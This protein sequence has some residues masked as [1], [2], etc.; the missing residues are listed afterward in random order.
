MED[1]I[2]RLG[3]KFFHAG[4]INA[5]EYHRNKQIF[6]QSDVISS[7]STILN[8]FVE[9][10]TLPT[11]QFGFTPSS[12]K[13]VK[14]EHM[15]D[16]DKETF[17]EHW[18]PLQ[19]PILRNMLIGGF[20]VYTTRKIRG[21][22]L[23]PMDITHHIGL[24]FDVHLFIDVHTFEEHYYVVPIQR[25]NQFHASFNMRHA[26]VVMDKRYHPSFETAKLTSVI[27]KL[28]SKHEFMIKQESSNL[29][30]TLLSA[31]PTA[32]LRAGPDITQEAL[33][34]YDR[35]YDEGGKLGTMLNFQLRQEQSKA[36]S[37]EQDF[38]DTQFRV[39]DKLQDN[40]SNLL[41][42]LQSN[43]E[44]TIKG[45]PPSLNMDYLLR[46]AIQ[47]LE[48]LPMKWQIDGQLQATYHNNWRDV[49]FVFI[50]MVATAFGVPNNLISG[51]TFSSVGRAAL[52][53][54]NLVVLAYTVNKWRT[55]I[56]EVMSDMFNTIHPSENDIPDIRI[57]YPKFEFKPM[58]PPGQPQSSPQ[59]QAQPQN[60]QSSSLESQNKR[61]RNDDEK[62]EKSQ[63]KKK[64]EDEKPQKKK[65]NEEEEE[66]KKK[67]S[68]KEEGKKS[69]KKSEDDEEEE[70]PKK[71]KSNEEEEEEKPKKK[72]SE[73][74][75]EEKEKPKKKKTKEE[76]EEEEEKPKKKKTEEEDEK[77]KKKK[78]KKEEKK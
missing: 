49:N 16:L 71:K 17:Y 50:N 55:V 57:V 62:E 58:L 51:L 70:K 52:S 24:H 46:P 15:E 56:G 13:Q 78:K 48:I 2:K 75:E 3:N 54:D 11:M 59:S 4:K 43:S 29:R 8:S 22:P 64:T 39:Y 77:K 72:K 26:K 45:P 1:L 73:K 25:S 76:E 66:P 63:K 5:A 14:G 23:V 41:T 40:A 36:K 60:S 27:S 28:A 68:T 7:V 31:D 30:A 19:V 20:T 74:D 65:S 21:G 38:A 18:Q 47:N 42:G 61:K 67:K 6:E 37:F 35:H 33:N 69:Q 12:K 53:E 44:L 9:C 34:L 32:F 10:D